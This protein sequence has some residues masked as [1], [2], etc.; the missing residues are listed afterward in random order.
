MKHSADGLEPGLRAPWSLC[1]TVRADLLATLRAVPP[2]HWARQPGPGRWSVAQQADHLLKAE[3]GTSKIV[4]RLIRGDYQNL[5][6][7]PGAALYDS[8]LDAYPFGPVAA[9]PALQPEG[10]DADEAHE[11]LA[12]A[13]ARFFE[14]LRRFAT[15]DPDAIVAPDPA[16][17]LWFTLA[18]WVR[19]QALH[20]AHH[21]LQIKA[22]ARAWCE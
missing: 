14:E 7:P 8:R 3:V 9:P 21:I 11:K 2:S 1:E 22:L 10:L 4:R 19:V 6:R 20:E 15:G 17:D 18:G 13:H 12:A 16:S 5:T